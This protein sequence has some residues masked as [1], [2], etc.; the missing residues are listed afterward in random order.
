MQVFDNPVLFQQ[1]CLEARRGGDLGLVPTMGY[2]HAGHR[3]L[4]DAAAKH[5]RSAL[6]IFVNPTQ[7][8]PQ[9]DFERYPRDLSRDLAMAEAAGIDFVLTPTAPQL[10]PPGF[11]TFVEPGPLAAELEGSIRPGHFRGVAT[12][13]LKLLTLAQPT[14]A[15]FG[16]KDYQ[17]FAV[18]RRMVM[19]FHLPL[20]V[21]GL[22]T[23]READG[24]ALSSRNAY[25]SP[26]ERGRALCLWH[27]LQAA[28]TAF[29]SGER[30]PSRLE[31]VA[32][33]A[34]GAGAD[35][36]DYVAVRDADSLETPPVAEPGRSVV[37][38]AAR[39]GRTRLIDN[40]ILE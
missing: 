34:V 28:Q 16:R 17:Q 23:V 19:D 27:G 5:F 2:L 1:A 13:V 22:P 18:I 10:Y 30:D 25:L 9:E 38:V 12:I 7:F 26:E 11:Q 21:E 32:T 39:V 8:G 35:R 14:H 20:E 29:Q 36:I 4:L 6:T 3:S 37:L 15:Y 24:L 40:L 31:S 33:E